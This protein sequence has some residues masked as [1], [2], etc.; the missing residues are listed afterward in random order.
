MLVTYRDKLGK[1]GRE[2]SD[3]DILNAQLELA[4]EKPRKLPQAQVTFE[5]QNPTPQQKELLNYLPTGKRTTRASMDMGMN[6]NTEREAVRH[7]ASRMGID[8]LDIAAIIDFETANA[9]TSGA[10]AVVL[11]NGVV[12]TWMD[13]VEALS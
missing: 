1:K 3:F 5:A 4:G 8:P 7:I 11:I 2:L 9:L 13:L 12:P 6:A 10:F